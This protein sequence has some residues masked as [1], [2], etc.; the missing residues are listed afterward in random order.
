[1]STT[2]TTDT[3]NTKAS[4]VTTSSENPQQITPQIS[5]TGELPT[6]VDNPTASGSVAPGESKDSLGPTDTLVRTPSNSCE[7]LQKRLDA[8]VEV[9]RAK[10]EKRE[11]KRLERAR[12][13]EGSE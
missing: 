12:R 13:K 10:W 3:Q 2:T 4:T 5:L 9:L 11:A 6:S 7:D 1:M 8:N